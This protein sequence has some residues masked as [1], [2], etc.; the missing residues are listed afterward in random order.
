MERNFIEELQDLCQNLQSGAPAEAKLRLAMDYP[1]DLSDR[2]PLI[3]DFCDWRNKCAYA[4]YL[5]KQNRPALA[6]RQLQF[7]S[8]DIDLYVT[9]SYMPLDE[10]FMRDLDDVA[11]SY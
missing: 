9:E 2:C 8:N 7:L 6:A 4:Y 1:E 11:K 5:Y 3:A 10:E